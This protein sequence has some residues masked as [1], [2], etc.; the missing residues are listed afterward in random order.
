MQTMRKVDVN[1]VPRVHKRLY[2]TGSGVVSENV[3]LRLYCDA[4][5][6]LPVA[7]VVSVRCLVSSSEASTH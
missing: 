4:P 5:R 3:D 7:F 1:T 2:L 6:L